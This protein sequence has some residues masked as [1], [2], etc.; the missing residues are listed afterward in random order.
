MMERLA[1][2]ECVIG[3]I[4]NVAPEDYEAL[5]EKWDT[6]EDNLVSWFEFREGLNR[7][8]WQMVDLQKL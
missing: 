1:T 7:W 2:D 3:K 5:F 6:N 4:P 8:P